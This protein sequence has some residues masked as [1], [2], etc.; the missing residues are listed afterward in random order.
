MGRV[1]GD[2]NLLAGLHTILLALHWVAHR[3]ALAILSI[4]ELELE[5]TSVLI[6]GVVSRIAAIFVNLA[7]KGSKLLKLWVSVLRRSPLARE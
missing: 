2:R 1:C 6:Y 4:D 5:S 3:G 7:G